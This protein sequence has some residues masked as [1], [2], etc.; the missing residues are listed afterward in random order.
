MYV[1]KP[2]KVEDPEKLEAFIKK[3]GRRMEVKPT[4]FQ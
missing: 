2:F 3:N 4:P 1:P